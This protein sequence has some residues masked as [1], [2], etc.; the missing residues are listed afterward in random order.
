M[1]IQFDR[2]AFGP[3]MMPFSQQPADTLETLGDFLLTP[4]RTALCKQ[5]HFS[6]FHITPKVELITRIALGVLSLSLLLPATLVGCIATYLSKTHA[7]FRSCIDVYEKKETE[8]R[9]HEQLRVAFEESRIAP[10]LP[11]AITFSTMMIPL[12]P[13][14]FD[15][16][17]NDNPMNVFGIRH[18]PPGVPLEAERLRQMEFVL[19]RLRNLMN[20][21]V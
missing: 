19:S 16:E 4:L 15:R 18:L 1:F 9:A 17:L 20:A 11:L 2:Q 8:K 21:A 10:P 12:P 3:L 7:L 6:T 14:L 13:L 5:F